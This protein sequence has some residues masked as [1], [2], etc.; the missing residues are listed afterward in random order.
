MRIAPGFGMRPTAS[1]SSGPRAAFAKRSPSPPP[2]RATITL[3]VISWRTTRAREAPSAVRIAI[4]LAREQQVGNVDASDQQNEPDSCKQHEQG[5]TN[6]QDDL[7]L[8]VNYVRAD[9]GVGIRILFFQASGDG[10]HLRACLLERHTRFQPRDREDPRMPVAII[11]KGFRPRLKRDKYLCRLQK[12]KSGWK[13]ADEGMR[14]RIENNR[15]AQPIPGAAKAALPERV[16]DHGDGRPTRTVFF[17]QKSAAR[18]RDDSEKRQKPGS[19]ASRDE[20]HRFTCAG[21]CEVREIGRFQGLEGAALIPPVFV[22]QIGGRSDRRELRVAFDDEKDTRGITKWE[23]PEQDSVDD[24][25][26][27]S[28]RA[29]TESERQNRNNRKARIL[30][31][32]PDAVF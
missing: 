25:K 1:L 2:S 23:R 27:R 4:S 19:D 31:E 15:F 26:D 20:T 29:D 16:A 5:G 17:G 11:W 24:S 10:F 3:S 7:V 8:H 21:E 28:V 12:L 14:L 13:H 18:H 32:H 30:Q 6:I 22:V 9:T